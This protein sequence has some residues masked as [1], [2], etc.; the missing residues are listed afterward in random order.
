MASVTG[1]TIDDFERLPQEQAKNHELVDGELVDV[2][3]IR[4][5]TIQFEIY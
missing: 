2:S 1:L 5:C 3:G 4:R